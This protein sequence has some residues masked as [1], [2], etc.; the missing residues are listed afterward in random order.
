MTPS[1][2]SHTLRAMYTTRQKVSTSLCVIPGPSSGYHRKEAV[3]G[4]R[5][6]LTTA[7]PPLHAYTVQDSSQERCH[8]L[9]VGLSASV[10]L[11]KE[12]YRK[13]SQ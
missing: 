1:L 2:A 11:T 7:Q 5:M 4:Q 6:Q 10:N 9:G 13:N 8:P 12:I 3:R